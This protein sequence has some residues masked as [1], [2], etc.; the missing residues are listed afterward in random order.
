MRRA[1]VVVVLG[2]VAA[3][4]LA[5]A[6]VAGADQAVSVQF[7]AFAPTPL[8]V[9]PGETVTWSNVSERAHTVTSDEGAFDSGQV[10]PGASFA[11]RFD[12]LG[13]HPYHC[14]LHPSMTGEVDV[15]RVILDPLPPA[16]VPAG[17]Q[18]EVTGRTADPGQPVRVQQSAG[19][20]AFA[21]VATATPGA[22]GAWKAS[23][24]AT[25][26]AD[27]R[28]V[29]DAGESETRPL[30]VSDRR[31]VVRVSGH[32]VHVTV[33]PSLPYGRVLVEQRLRERFGWWPVRRTRLDYV[34]QA[35][36]VLRRPGR[37]R[38]VLVDRDGWTPLAT[39]RVVRVAGDHRPPR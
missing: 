11:Q 16:A 18:V 13:A 35:Q 37:V 1:R 32:G 27:V 39:S 14:V 33:T 24:P 4:A 7:A 28:A 21:T 6:P 20:G 34:S 8:D 15:R 25:A 2:A 23:V 22:D 19:G 10:A 26:T 31:V 9:L 12:G 38:V 30:L 17:E 3:A 29:S 5:G 36:V